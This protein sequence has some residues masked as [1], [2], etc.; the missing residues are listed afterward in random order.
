VRCVMFRQRA[1]SVAFT[2]ANGIEVEVRAL[3]SLYEARGEFQLG[4]ETMRRSGVGA[5]FEA[6]E[7]LKRKLSDE[8]WFDAA[9]KRAL[10]DFARSIGIVTSL[11]AAALQDVLA[12]FKRR[13]PMIRIVIYP[14]A[15]QGADAANE[16]ASAITTAARRAEVD[17]LLI[18]RGGGAAEDLWSFNEEQV[19]RAII[20][21]QMQARVPVVSG[22][23]HETDFTICDFV[24]DLRAPTPTAAAELLSPDTPRLRAEVE[25]RRQQLRRQ[26]Q[27]RLTNLQQRLDLAA[28]GLVSPSQRLAD[29]RVRVQRSS[30][31][32]RRA[33]E[34]T[35][36]TH[37]MAVINQS[38]RLA[39]A[40]PDLSRLGVELAASATALRHAGTRTLNLVQHRLQQQRQALAL[41]NPDNVLSRGYMIVTR[42]DVEHSIVTAAN[43][44]AAHDRV[45]MRFHDGSVEAEVQ[46]VATRPDG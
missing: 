23:G 5:L 30:I 13:A 14:T 9:R 38:H 15:V 28:R 8:G 35:R 29:A 17:A 10:P 20:D 27:N 16:I 25:A 37:R 18:C 21:F 46:S 19:A 36:S 39:H 41:L 12:T 1:Q 42:A 6:F 22:V 26:L 3:P 4:V 33:L 44:V 2:P 7:R 11:K 32:L 43:A 31:Q 24:A 45:V 40:K 34:Q